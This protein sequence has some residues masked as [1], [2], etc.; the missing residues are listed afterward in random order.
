[1]WLHELIPKVFF[2]PIF[3][4]H[5][6]THAIIF[7]ITLSARIIHSRY[8]PS[9]QP[10][11]ILSSENCSQVLVAVWWSV[12]TVKL[13]VT[14]ET[15][16]IPLKCVSCTMYMTR[17]TNFI[18]FHCD[19]VTLSSVDETQQS[20][21]SYCSGPEIEYSQPSVLL[22]IV[23][24]DFSKAWKYARKQKNVHVH[25]TLYIVQCTFIALLLWELSGCTGVGRAWALVQW[26]VPPIHSA[27]YTCIW[28]C[29]DIRLYYSHLSP[30]FLCCIITVPSG[31]YMY[32]PPYCQVR[33]YNHNNY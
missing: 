12:R 23:L 6:P 15:L 7:I 13:R 19:S 21:N 25:C 3:A 5:H 14:E 16:L 11:S 30:F 28:M 1:M 2:A 24:M 18:R 29:I 33:V 20:Q 32:L 22:N 4:P 31:V 9:L 26:V 27:L 17:Q 10:I 8:D